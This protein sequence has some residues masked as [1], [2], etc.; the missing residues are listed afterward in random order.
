ML[1]WATQQDGL[2][3]LLWVDDPATEG[4]PVPEQVA[5]QQVELAA[6]FQARAYL[7]GLGI[8]DFDD[9]FKSVDEGMLREVAGQLGML[10]AVPDSQGEQGPAAGRKV[11]P[12]H[13]FFN[14]E[15]LSDRRFVGSVVNSALA[16]VTT[17]VSRLLSDRADLPDELQSQLFF[18]GIDARNIESPLATQSDKWQMT[19]L[20]NGRWANSGAD[21]LL[22]APFETLAE[23]QQL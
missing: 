12:E 13:S 2:P 19:Q 10:G 21:G 20:P 23:T 18:V 17:R 3:P 4:E 5:D 1:R 16:P 6:H 15:G 7:N 11:E 8:Y 22:I 9:Q 14:L